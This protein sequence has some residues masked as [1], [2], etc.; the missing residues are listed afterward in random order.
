MHSER[1]TSLHWERAITA[2]CKASSVGIQDLLRIE[3]TVIE[4][5]QE[6]IEVRLLMRAASQRAG[7]Q[8]DPWNVV[9][10]PTIRA[11]YGQPTTIEQ[12]IEYPDRNRTADTWRIV[13]TPQRI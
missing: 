2:T 5:P 6:E 13:L 9:A 7:I 1:M 4:I 12:V 10:K 8:R 11:S 3:T